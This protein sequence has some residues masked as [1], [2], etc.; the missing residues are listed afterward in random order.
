VVFDPARLEAVEE[1]VDAIER[2]KRKYGGTLAAVRAHRDQAAREL[3]ELVSH[4]D[5]LG[6]LGRAR[7]TALETA[8]S[9]AT[10]LRTRR[11]EAASRL[12]RAISD[13]LSSLG[14]GDARVQVDVA[15]LAG[16]KDE[17][18][19]SGARLSATGIDRV[20]LLIAPN[21]GEVARPL[22]K[23]AS[24]GE[25]S[26][27]L[28]AIKRV[29]A[30]LGPAGLYVFDEVDAGVG[31]GVADVIGNKLE[32]VAQHHQVLCITHL[33]QIAVYA[34][35]HFLA[36]KD[37]VDDRTVSDIRRLSDRQRKE[38]VARMLGGLEITTKTR[39][40]A[41]E[42]LARAQTRRPSPA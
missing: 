8:R 20:E 4:E 42:M 32:E 23:V 12:G 25:L 39:A 18:S 1:R 2:L 6:Q 26:R 33:P 38:E 3:D 22:R 31:G 10:E 36:Q 34:D 29:L 14:M 11:H 21:R 15:P 35:T 9:I 24:G 13:E 19:V 7:D 28:L 40:A 27:S 30:G 17:L 37:V 16:A 5:R 41:A